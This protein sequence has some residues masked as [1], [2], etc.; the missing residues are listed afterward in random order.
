MTDDIGLGIA[1]AEHIGAFA[2]AQLLTLEGSDGHIGDNGATE[3][4]HADILSCLTYLGVV[5]EYFVLLL[6]P[7]RQ[8][9]H[10]ERAGDEAAVLAVEPIGGI[11]GM[12]GRQDRGTVL[13]GDTDDLGTEVGVQAQ[14]VANGG[15]EQVA[16]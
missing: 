3:R 8:L 12:T 13:I 9:V 1:Y 2:L 7:L 11:G 14:L 16:R 4:C 10:I 5:A 15:G 6:Y